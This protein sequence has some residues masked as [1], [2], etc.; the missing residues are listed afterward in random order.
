MSDVAPV[1]SDCQLPETHTAIDACVVEEHA[2][3]CPKAYRVSDMFSRTLKR[4]TSVSPAGP[5][6]RG[7]AVVIDDDVAPRLVPR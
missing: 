2:E 1:L 4:D 7:R 3:T 5:V 6:G